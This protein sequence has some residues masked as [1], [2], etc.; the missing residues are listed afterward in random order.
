VAI[1]AAMLVAG[2][3]DSTRSFRANY[4][5]VT[6]HPLGDIEAAK[7]ANEQGKKHLAEGNLEAAREAFERACVADRDFGAAHNNLGKVYYKMDRAGEAA[8][9]F[10]EARR[11]MPEDPRPYYN[12]G[13]TL[14]L[15]SPPQYDSAV[16]NF[17]EALKRDEG[18]VRYLAN[19]AAAMSERG[20]RSDEHRELLERVAKEDVREEWARWARRE[21]ANRYGRGE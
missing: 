15:D 3:Q 14:L 20:D 13:L 12:L 16:E 17:R 7:K 8:E 11:L 6:A 18:N 1:L 10:E 5:T 21:L 4:R 2:C 9:E 19:L